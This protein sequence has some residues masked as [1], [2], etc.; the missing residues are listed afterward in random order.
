MSEATEAMT[1]RLG[2][3]FYI[4]SFYRIYGR[5]TNWLISRRFMGLLDELKCANLPGFVNYQLVVQF[6]RVKPGRFFFIH[7]P[8]DFGNWL[9]INECIQ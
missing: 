4:Q 2:G 7:W 5:T 1:G 9:S 8:P 6:D 3:I